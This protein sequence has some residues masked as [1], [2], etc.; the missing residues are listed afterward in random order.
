MNIK[1]KN[2][3]YIYTME[4]KLDNPKTIIVKEEETIT[5]DTITI[6]EVTDNGTSVIALIIF[7]GKDPILKTKS[8]ILWDGDDYDAIGQWTDDDVQNRIKEIIQNQQ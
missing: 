1:I 8:I 4:V 7:K 6:N 5:S 2:N 3:Q